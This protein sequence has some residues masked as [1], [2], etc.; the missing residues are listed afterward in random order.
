MLK[1]I[2]FQLTV[3]V[4]FT[5]FSL[6]AVENELHVKKSSKVPVVFDGNVSTFEYCDAVRVNFRNGHGEVA[7]YVKSDGKFI[8]FAFE[9]PDKSVHL[10]DDIVIML[11]TDNMRPENPDSND[12]RAY[13]RRKLENSRM[14][15]GSKGKWA[16]YWGKWEYC[17]RSYDSGWEVECRLPL[18]APA[19]S[20]FSPSAKD[21]TGEKTVRM[22]IAFRIWDN[23]PQK[24]WSWPISSDENKPD[25][26]A[27]LVLE[28]DEKNK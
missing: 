28:E 13:I 25:T 26:W 2:L 16:D 7:A 9:I 24:K 3:F 20:A 17:A 11:D 22:G 10:G 1:Q 23:S 18:N 14:Q 6:Y 4:L 8:Y 19:D 12:V 5:T 27:T 21:K 15:K